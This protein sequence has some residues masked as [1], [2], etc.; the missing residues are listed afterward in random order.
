MG[1]ELKRAATCRRAHAPA[2]HGKGDRSD[3]HGHELDRAQQ[4]G[5]QHGPGRLR[6]LLI[7]DRHH[8]G[9]QQPRRDEGDGQRGQREQQQS[10][11]SIHGSLP[12]T[13]A[14]R[15]LPSFIRTT[16]VRID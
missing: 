5:G 15:R 16:C 4:E 1:R 10:P 6:L 14:C 13:V 11:S 9:H 2:H 8:V 3:P 7:S 12:S